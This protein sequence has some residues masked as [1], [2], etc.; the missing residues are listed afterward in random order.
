MSHAITALLLLQLDRCP[1]E[2][3]PVHQLAMHLSLQRPVV[4]DHLLPLAD[5]GQVRLQRDPT[6]LVDAAMAAPGDCAGS[7]AW[8][9]ADAIAALGR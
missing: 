9:G 7:T 1:G 3:V 6:G 8:Q 5:A 4:C 2:W